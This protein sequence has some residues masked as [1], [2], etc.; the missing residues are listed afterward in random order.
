MWYQ[1]V[2]TPHALEKT[3]KKNLIF[4]INQA[5]NKL[6]L[7]KMRKPSKIINITS[8]NVDHVPEYKLTRIY[9]F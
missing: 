9:K 8:K 5:K 1:T 3:Q 7:I 4:H 2:I 6:Q